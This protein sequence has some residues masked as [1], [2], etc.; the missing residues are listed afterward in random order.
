MALVQGTMLYAA[1]LTWN[2]QT[3]VEGGYQRAIN[4]MG[5]ST[6]GAFKYTPQGIVTAESGLTLASVTGHWHTQRGARRT[7]GGA[8]TSA[9]MTPTGSMAVEASA[10]AWLWWH[11]RMAW[12]WECRQTA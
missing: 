8:P 1:E 4:R 9:F 3:G 11:R 2:G 10:G 6:L 5:R 12:L 7:R